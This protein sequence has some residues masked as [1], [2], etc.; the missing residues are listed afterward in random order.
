DQGSDGYPGRF[1]DLRKAVCCRVKQ[2]YLL[3]AVDIAA[4]QVTVGCKSDAFA[5]ATDCWERVSESERSPGR[6][7]NLSK[8]VS[9][10]VVEKDLRVMVGILAGQVAV[11]HKNDARPIT[12]DCG[13]GI[14]ST[15][16]EGDLVDAARDRVGGSAFHAPRGCKG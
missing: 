2:K 9:C 5:I 15:G 14:D 7:G 1:G 8:A 11:G 4:G 13:L 12:I 6:I 10:R 16:R 3:V